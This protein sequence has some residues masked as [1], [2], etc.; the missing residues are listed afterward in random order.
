MLQG[1]TGSRLFTRNFDEMHA[2][3]DYRLSY[4]RFFKLTR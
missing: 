4:L 3:L 1:K 2:R